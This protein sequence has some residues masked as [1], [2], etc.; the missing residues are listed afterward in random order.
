MK[1]EVFKVYLYC[2]WQW[3]IMR[4][5]LL[6]EPTRFAP[7]TYLQNHRNAERRHNARTLQLH[8]LNFRRG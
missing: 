2:N 8:A 5:C 3:G 7:V 6:A 4:K 1:A